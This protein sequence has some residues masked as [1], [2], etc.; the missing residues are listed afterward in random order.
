MRLSASRE[1]EKIGLQKEI[2]ID[3]SHYT[4]TKEITIGALLVIATLTVLFLINQ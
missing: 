3:T 2:F 4:Y 1:E